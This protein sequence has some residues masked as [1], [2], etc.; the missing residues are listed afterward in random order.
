MNEKPFALLELVRQKQ[1]FML[2]KFKVSGHV[3]PCRLFGT[4]QGHHLRKISVV[5]VRKPNQLQYSLFRTCEFKSVRRFLE[6][7]FN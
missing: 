7:V 1:T 5:L 2:M 4:A 3:T 6:G